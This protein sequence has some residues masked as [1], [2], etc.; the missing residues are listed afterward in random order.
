MIRRPSALAIDA[1]IV[2]IYADAVRRAFGTTLEDP[3]AAEFAR[4]MISLAE[5]MAD[6]AEETARVQALL[7]LEVP[8]P[9]PPKPS[10]RVI[11]GDRL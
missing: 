3:A 6:C 7:G 11:D 8:S 9:V 5:S 4:A 10:L 2:R 1:Q